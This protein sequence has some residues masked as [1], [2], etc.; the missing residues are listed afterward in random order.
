V[1]NRLVHPKRKTIG[2]RIPDN[3]IVKELVTELAEPIMSSSLIMPAE[4][5]PLGDPE[6]IRER[7]EHQVDLVIDGGVITNQP[8]TVIDW[9][10][11]RL[12][13]LRQG[14][15]DVAFLYD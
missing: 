3:L 10:E 15:G 5:L 14:L 1:P 11:E 13:V 4:E 7:L 6:K 9:H 12:R 2:V 8:S